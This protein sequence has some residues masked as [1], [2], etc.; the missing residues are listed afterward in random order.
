[1]GFASLDNALLSTSSPASKA[2]GVTSPLLWSGSIAPDM[3]LDVNGDKKITKEDARTILKCI[4][5][6]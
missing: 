6:G 2:L 5:K 1:M 3:T 4:V